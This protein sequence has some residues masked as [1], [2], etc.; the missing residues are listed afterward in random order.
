MVADLGVGNRAQIAV[1]TLILQQA[2]GRHFG[3]AHFQKL[4]IARHD[5]LGIAQT[6][7]MHYRALSGF[8]SFQP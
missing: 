1:A 2:L 6:R 3:H 8:A 5:D 4:A 7:P